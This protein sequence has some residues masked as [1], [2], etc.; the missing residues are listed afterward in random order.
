MAKSQTTEAGTRSLP[1]FTGLG[2]TVRSRSAVLG[3]YL[4]ARRSI[5]QP[6]A[7][8]LSEDSAR[9]VS[10]LRREEVAALAGISSDYYLRLEQ[11]RGQKPSPQ[12]VAALSRALALDGDGEEYLARLA[13]PAPPMPD[14]RNRTADDPELQRLVA[15]HNAP[16]FVADEVIGVVASNPLA[17]ALS[18]SMQPGVNRLSFMFT[19]MD[20]S[21]YPEWAQRAREMVAVFRMRSD[22]SD[23]R[24][25][26]IAEDLSA[27]DADFAIYWA[28]YDVRVFRSGLAYEVIEPF[29][30]LEFECEDLGI[31]GRDGLTLTTLYAR[32]G[33]REAAVI[34]YVR[35]GLAI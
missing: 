22:P 33:S 19:A 16:S 1:R 17:A 8:G 20:R 7:V 34:A 26:R 32:P 10:G 9:R 29:G 23:P 35:A 2:V 15:R 30:L 5:T 28:T 27:R 31:P 24:A 25:L 11:G 3:E 21:V 18:E 13:A 4:R 14:L 6:T 12:V